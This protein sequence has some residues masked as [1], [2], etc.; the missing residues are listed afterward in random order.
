MALMYGKEKDSETLD[1]DTV[2]DPGFCSFF[3]KLPAK[4]PETHGTLRL[5]ARHASDKDYFSAHGPDAH[6]VAQHVFHT[7]SVIKWLG[8]GSSGP[9]KT[10]L[11]SVT[12]NEMMA[13]GF[14]R[15]AL[16]AKQ[17]RVEIW[18]PEKGQGK[19][20]TKFVL[21]K[22][23]SPGNLQAVED[24]L[25]VNTDLMTAPM[26]MAIKIASSSG[27]PGS[28]YVKA[29][30]KNIGV[31]FADT[32]LRE[33]GVADFADNDLFSNTESLIIQ[34]GIKE[35]LVP[36]GTVSGKTDRDVDLNKLKA[37]LERCGVVCTERKPSEFNSRSVEDDLTRLLKPEASSSTTASTS[38]QLSLPVAPASL[39]ALITY[40]SLLSDPAN[41]G[42]WT[43]RTHD[44]SQFMKLDASALRALNLV[45]GPNGETSANKNTTLL[46]LLNKCKTAQGTRMLASWLKQPLVNLHEIRKRQDLVEIFVEDANSR[47][48]LQD[49]YLKLMP[50]LHRISKR[51]QKNAASLEDVVRVYQAV[52]KLPGIIESLAN[53]ESTSMH[54]KELIDEI[55]LVKLREYDGSLNKYG[56]MVETTIDLNELDNHNYVIK[57]DYDPK[58]QELAEKLMKTRDGLDDE[59]REVG[60]DLGLELDKQIFLENSPT[61]GYCF[62]LTKGV[63]KAVHNKKNYYELATTKSGAF[64]TT[65]NLRDLANEYKDLTDLYARTQAGL[66]KEIVSIASTYT[67]VLELFNVVLAHLDVI[68]S[69]AHVAVNAPEAYVKPKVLQK[70]SSS[71]ILKAARHPCLEVQDDISF[72][73]NDVEMIKG[74]GEFQ[75][76]TGPNMGGK[77]TYIRQVGVIALMAQV[78]S[79]VPCEEAQLPIFDSILCRVGAGDSQLKGIS[80][81]MAEMLE[82]AAILRSASS[83]S[84]IIIDELGRGT[85]TYDGFGLAWAISEHIA[86]K[87]HAFCMFATHFHELTSLDQQLPHVRNLHVVAHVSKRGSELNDRD[88]TLLYKVEPGVCDQS[89]GIHVAELANFPQSVVKLARRKANE[90]E[91]FGRDEAE[92]AEFS[93]EV[94][95]EGVELVEELLRTWATRSAGGSDEDVDMDAADLTP[96]QQLEELKRCVETFKPRIEANPWVRSLLTEL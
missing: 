39:N 90:L 43:I 36:T 95:E 46:G 38:E 42:T 89:F 37:V 18:V 67:P 5:F 44:L 60:R 13:K 65:S 54:A 63:S 85:S 50:D 88:I 81:F 49:E 2:T 48:T 86:S 23:A 14:L 59:H 1:L 79:F 52:L 77:S 82:T 29:T 76:I 47:R 4:S 6:Y 30:T 24:M 21:D 28:T 40:L 25:F 7:N 33:I 20:A 68:L 84:L 35:C 56:E 80:T 26:V 57:P 16:T 45:D 53:V 34:L 10:G 58:L 71:L 70:G 96:E 55:Y 3:A 93:E 94:T 41:H 15:E 91:D 64:F 92:D 12:M 62:R 72:I 74:E 11:A 83:N 78:G 8:K 17:L 73:P 9:N 32:T 31:A 27:P 66:V 69:M 75:I 87:I 61:Y 51:F 19:K 22:E